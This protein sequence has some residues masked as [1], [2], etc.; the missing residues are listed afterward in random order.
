MMAEDRRAPIPTAKKDDDEDVSWA[1]S[2]AEAMWTRGEH[3]DAVKW[4]RRAAEAAAEAQADDRALELAKAAAD[5]TSQVGM[6]AAPE[7]HVQV[8]P[9]APS[10]P[11]PLPPKATGSGPPKSASA[12]PP[13]PTSTPPKSMAPGPKSVPPPKSIPAPKSIP[14][15]PGSATARP[16]A[17]PPASGRSQ[18]PP[19]P[20]PSAPGAA[21]MKPVAGAPAKTPAPPR[22]P[23]VATTTGLPRSASGA[24]L[25][26]ARMRDEPTVTKTE[27]RR[28]RRSS[29]H[30]LERPPVVRHAPDTEVTQQV[31]VPHRRR[32]SSK[33][34][35]AEVAP[36]EPTPLPPASQAP[37]LDRATTE[38]MDAWPTLMSTT[39]TFHEHEA[40]H[41]EK[42]RIGAAAYVAEVAQQAA[43]APAPEPLLR[44][45]DG[46]YGRP[47]QALRVVIWRS[48]DGLRIAP[49]GATPP[50][51]SIEALLVALDPAADL[52]EWLKR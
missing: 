18:P 22:A 41:E 51:M 10:R 26:P 45:A 36:P 43:E 14:P 20:A 13:K 23:I 25:P 24:P 3:H 52:T 19:K 27:P 4:L 1:L 49:Q 16:G 8:P 44:T 38:E 31:A 33:P 42:T 28:S 48:S 29:S 30:D 15:R 17:P 6:R 32:R 35:P 5:L 21:A 47:H 12:P 39:E 2:T 50:G 37:T 7:V 34:A 40:T 9:P 11:P 46:A